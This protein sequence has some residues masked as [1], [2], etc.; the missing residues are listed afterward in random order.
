LAVDQCPLYESGHLLHRQRVKQSRFQK[1][2]H[3]S[4][5]SAVFVK[6]LITLQSRFPKV[7][8]SH[9]INKTLAFV[10]YLRQT[11]ITPPAEPQVS[12]AATSESGS[13]EYQSR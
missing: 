8:G 7:S 11:E 2:N 9:Y 4:N 5:F 10:D 1:R 6:L 12:L 3:R 13:P